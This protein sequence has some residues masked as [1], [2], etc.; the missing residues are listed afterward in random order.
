MGRWEQ[1]QCLMSVLMSCSS[2]GQT[3]H[4]GSITE[5]AHCPQARTELPFFKKRQRGIPY[6]GC[7]SDEKPFHPAVFQSPLAALITGP[8]AALWAHCVH[9]GSWE[10]A[11][12][13]ILT[14]QIK[15]ARTNTH[16]AY[17][18]AQE[19]EPS[20]RNQSASCSG[21]F[22]SV[23]LSVWLQQLQPA[24]TSSEAHRGRRAPLLSHF[25][26]R[27]SR[28]REDVLRLSTYQTPGKV[29][30]LRT[31]SGNREGTIRHRRRWET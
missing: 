28:S 3:T 17:A 2:C 4:R 1:E 30:T 11:A 31:Q 21:T 10:K 6:V 27:T 24:E 22:L 14:T 19:P 16:S 8:G 12:R 5:R 26:S 13:L 29:F 7:C 15:T 18:S 20:Q 23:C 25:Q 9:A